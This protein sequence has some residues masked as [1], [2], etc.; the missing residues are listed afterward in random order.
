MAQEIRQFSANVPA[1]TPQNTPAQFSLRF[2]PRDVQ[3]IE[4]R[5]PPGPSGLMGFALQMSGVTVIPY[6]SDLFIVTADDKLEWDLEGYPNSGDWQLSAFN[7]D[8]NPH[9]VF[10]RFL[11]VM[12]G[13]HAAPSVP[14]YFSDASLA[15]GVLV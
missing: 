10:V 8:T 11:L 5:V 12:P 1:N 4:I 6:G 13:S 3:R 9:T 15:G 14:V 2:P 7:T